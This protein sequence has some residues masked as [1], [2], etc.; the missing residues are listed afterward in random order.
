MLLVACV[1]RAKRTRSYTCHRGFISSVNSL[2][3]MFVP[4]SFP[5][6][7]A[8]TRLGPPRFGF[9]VPAGAAPSPLRYQAPRTSC[10]GGFQNVTPFGQTVQ[11]RA[12][13]PRRARHRPVAHP[14]RPFL[15]VPGMSYPERP[16]TTTTAPSTTYQA[17]RRRTHRALPRVSTRR[18]TRG[19][20]PRQA[21]LRS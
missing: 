4:S 7:F 8:Y 13:R 18:L 15:R 19:S 17:K 20:P 16:A 1:Y 11:I 21:I 14:A 6:L 3:S 9:S 12:R 5:R 2:E 10:T